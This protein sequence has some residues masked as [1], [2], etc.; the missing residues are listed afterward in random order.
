MFGK[1]KQNVQLTE[2]QIRE[3]KKNMSA[4]ELRQFNKDQKDLARKQKR[5]KDDAFWDGLLWGSIFLDD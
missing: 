2:K 3:L 4:K 5:Q 1:K